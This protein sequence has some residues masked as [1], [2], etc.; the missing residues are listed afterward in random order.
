MAH[1][2][3]NYLPFSFPPIS[4]RSPNSLY[5]PSLTPPTHPPPH[6]TPQHTDTRS[7]HPLGSNNRSLNTPRDRPSNSCLIEP[8]SPPHTHIALIDCPLLPLPNS[9]YP[10]LPRP[11]SPRQGPLWTAGGW[12]HVSFQLWTHCG[13]WWLVCLQMKAED[14]R[15]R[16][17]DEDRRNNQVAVQPKITY[18]CM[19][20]PFSFL[21]FSQW[22][23]L[24][25]R[26]SWLIISE[27]ADDS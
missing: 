15:L 16:D 5:I 6:P 7:P 24:W 2:T 4:K 21:F 11:S 13:L 27:V 3:F 9:P 10:S 12:L 26:R 14:C 17:T 19:S 20:F 8:G 1:D 25:Q 18:F 23:K 22:H